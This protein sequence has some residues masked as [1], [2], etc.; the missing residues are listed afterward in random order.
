MSAA[1]AAGGT[2]Q[3]SAAASPASL[4]TALARV[5]ELA[6]GKE[7][8]VV[9]YATTHGSPQA[10]LVYRDAARG[11][12]AIPPRRLAAMLG[13]AGV[14]N[15]LLILSACYSGVFVP[16][17]AD[18]DSVVITAAAADRSSFGCSPGNDWTFF[19]DALIN[20]ALRTARPIAAAFAD[21]RDA[22]AGW[23][24]AAKLEGSRPQISVGARADRWL[25][26]LEKRIPP[27]TTASVGRSPADAR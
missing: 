18:A 16:A 21:A 8:V 17:L 11:A 27:E 25:V 19:G 13:D 3:P 4:A 1:R 6:D 10:G 23:E 2:A 22:V 12:G 26:P 7:D 9:L 14:R 20:R 24:A 15:R 5:G